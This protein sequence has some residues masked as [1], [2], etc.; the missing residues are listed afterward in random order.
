MK[1]KLTES[2]K[3]NMIKMI[4]GFLPE[5]D[6][7]ATLEDT[8]FLEEIIAKEFPELYGEWSN[9]ICLL[10]QAIENDPQKTLQLRKLIEAV[11]E[12]EKNKN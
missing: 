11:A 1:L 12:Y 10:I 5:C 6:Y 3:N 2:M 9:L 7:K 8:Q 4:Q